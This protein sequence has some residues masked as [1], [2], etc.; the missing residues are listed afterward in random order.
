MQ[1]TQLTAP[2][3]WASLQG[4]FSLTVRDYSTLLLDVPPQIRSIGGRGAQE[5]SCVLPGDAEGGPAAMLPDN[6]LACFSML[7]AFAGPSQQTHLDARKETAGNTGHGG[8]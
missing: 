5:V 8:E 2:L 3:A 1:T 7:L 4:Y 6:P